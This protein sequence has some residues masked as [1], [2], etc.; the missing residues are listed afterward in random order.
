MNNNW[1]HDETVR[2]DLERFIQENRW[3]HARMAAKLNFSSTRVTKYLNLNKVGNVA[4]PDAKRV[5]AAGKQ[6]LR[7]VG[8]LAKIDEALFENSVSQSVAAT[9]R[10]IR[11]TGDI[12]LIHSNGGKGKT[13]GALLYSRDNPNTLYMTINQWSGG[14][15]SCMRMLF[16][17]F[18]AQSTEEWPGNIS[19]ADWMAAQLRGTERL[20]IVDDAELLDISGIKYFFS[21]HDATG[22]AI[23][24]IGNT[25][26]IEKIQRN[27]PAG[28]LISRIGIVEQVE[29]EDDAKETALALIGQ[30]APASGQEL[31]DVA[32]DVVTK[33]GFARRLRKQLT[34][35]N[36]IKEGN[37]DCTWQDAFAAAAGKLITPKLQ[38]GRAV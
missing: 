27:D 22:I 10:L 30:F 3:T 7:H 31:V 29:M 36:I 15:C 32:T 28:K 17:E 11:R 26:V 24:L 37:P 35:T 6:F 25:V 19:R 38:S 21:L 8:R 20:L 9:L 5:E 14:S 18:R 12:G 4:E 33:A 23:A 2:A 13:S 16:D 1:K 34:L